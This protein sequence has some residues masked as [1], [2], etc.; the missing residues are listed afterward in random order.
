VSD[1]YRKALDAACR[2]YEQVAAEHARLETRLG[3]LKQTIGTLN[4]LCG[5]E[6]T[7]PWS[8][9]DACRVILRSAGRPMTAVEVRNSLDAAGLDFTKYSNALSAIHTVLKRLAE[10]GQVVPKDVDE[11]ERVAYQFLSSGMVAS[12]ITVKSQPR[13][14]ARKK[15]ESWKR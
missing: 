5:F 1:D 7:V 2:E 14:R 15:Q 6:P 3:Q 4:K 11:S 12:R 13:R 8:L 9:T 10:G